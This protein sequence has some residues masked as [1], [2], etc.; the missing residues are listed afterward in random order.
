MTTDPPPDERKLHPALGFLGGREGQVGSTIYGTLVVLT[1]TTAG[2]A[3]E[4]HRPGHLI[5]LVVAAVLGFWVAY[6]YAHALSGS[7]EQR[8]RL[9]RAMI[10]EVAHDENGI[11]LAAIPPVFA[12][13]L[14][15]LG[16][17]DESVSIWLAIALGIVVLIIEGYRYSRI[18]RLSLTLTIG[19]VAMNVAIGFG[20]VLLKLS[21]VH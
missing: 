14:G 4:R 12:L 11:L 3:A 13:L 8:R 9:S 15:A 10:V 16:V 21:L 7:I 2:Y 20:V 5:Q 18:E 19:I 1:A 6:V 17:I